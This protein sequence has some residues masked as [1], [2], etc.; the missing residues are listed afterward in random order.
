MWY[1]IMVKDEVGKNIGGSFT[2]DYEYHFKTVGYKHG[3]ISKNGDSQ[4]VGGE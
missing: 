4:T 2:K 1:R 3:E